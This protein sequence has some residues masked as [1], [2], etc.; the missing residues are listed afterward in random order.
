M[1]NSVAQYLWAATILLFGF[2]FKTLLSKL[3]TGVIFK[4][5]KRFSD[6]EGQISLKR[7]LIQPLEMVVF[8]VFLFFAVNV[9]NYPFRFGGPVLQISLFRIYQIFIIAAI[10]WV[11]TRFIDFV[12]MMFQRRASHT[13]SKLDDQLIPFFKDFTKVL[14]YIF[15]FLVV[16]GSVFGVNVAAIVASL[17]VGGLAIAFA[18]KE[19]LENLLASFTIFLDHPFVIG[20]LVEVGG[21]TGVIEKIGFRSTRIRTLEKTFVTVPNKSMIDKPLNNLSLRT[22]RRVQF[23]VNLTYD[24][25]SAQIKAI[26]T[27]L[28]EFIDN[29]PQTNQDGRIRFQNLGASSKDVMV[30]YFVEALDWNE[31]INIKEEVAYKIVEV[32][33]RHRA[34]FAFPTQTL[35][36]Y[37]EQK[38]DALPP[39]ETANFPSTDLQ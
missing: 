8:L 28:Q 5:V 36:V 20:D 4:L 31:F 16:L 21:I 7:F 27:E 18:A 9:L 12:G 22:F 1:G 3:I 15:A 39:P 24:T 35:H 14:V 23:D 10:T 25:S 29:H 11:I 30:L 34:D 13:T 37:K 38:Q 2:I 17:G 33:E 26:T 6:E 19:S 32:V